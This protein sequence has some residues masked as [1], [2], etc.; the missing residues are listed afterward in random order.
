M[1]A[2]SD[3]SGNIPL[4]ELVT[5]T[6]S[7]AIVVFGILKVFVVSGPSGV[8]LPTTVKVTCTP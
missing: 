1:I 8:S 2:T 6:G 3:K 7:S 5:C 4:V